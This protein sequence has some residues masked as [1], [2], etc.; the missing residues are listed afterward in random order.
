MISKVPRPSFI[1]FKIPS[2]YHLENEICKKHFYINLTY[3]ITIEYRV[4]VGQVHGKEEVGGNWA[5]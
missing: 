4:G 1:V 2:S 5:H 3:L